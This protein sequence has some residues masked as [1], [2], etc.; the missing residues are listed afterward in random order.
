MPLEYLVD[1]KFLEQM[2]SKLTGWTDPVARLRH[3][4]EKDE[5]ELYCQPIVSLAGGERY[6]MGEV[7]VRMREEEKA[8][9]AQLSSK[10]VAP[11]RLLFEIDES[12]V[13]QRPELAA[14]FVAAYRALSR[15]TAASHAG[16]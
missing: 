15:S 3:A 8:L 2:D 13:L 6:P 11:D 14:K 5:F 10:Q 12:D 7:L 4:L 1:D 9:L 16:S